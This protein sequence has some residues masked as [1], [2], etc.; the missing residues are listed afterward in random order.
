MQVQL[1]SIA[2]GLQ[3]VPLFLAQ[4]LQA[5]PHECPSQTTL[6]ESRWGQVKDT[7]G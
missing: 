4:P 6:R 2:V 3:A 7:C 1:K 5:K